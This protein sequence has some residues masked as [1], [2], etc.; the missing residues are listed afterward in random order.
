[1]NYK[2]LKN[3][4]TKKTFI[5]LSLFF[6]PLN[7]FA[8]STI[9]ISVNTNLTPSN[10]P[11]NASAASV[12]MTAD[13]RYVLFDSNAT[14]LVSGSVDTNNATDVFLRDNVTHTTTLISVS[15]AGNTAGNWASLSTSDTDNQSKISPDGRYVLFQSVSSDL[16]TWDTPYSFD[17]FVRDTVAHTTTKVNVNNAWVWSSG[18]GNTAYWYAMTPDGRYVVFYTDATNLV[19]WDTNWQVD[20]FVRDLV[21]NTTTRVSVWDSDNQGNNQSTPSGIS[22]NGR[23]VLFDSYA[24]NLFPWDTNG[25]QDV[26]VRD[27][28]AGTTTKISADSNGNFGNGISSSRADGS[29]AITP[30][31]RYVMFQS[32]ASNLVD[33]DTNNRWDIFVKDM[34]TNITTKVT[35]TIPTCTI[36][37]PCGAIGAENWWPIPVWWWNETPLDWWPTPVWWVWDEDTPI[38]WPAPVWWPAQIWPI[39]EFTPPVTSTPVA[40]TPDGRYVLFSS[41]ATDYVANDTNSQIDGFVRDRVTNTTTRV[42]VSSN[43][44]QHD[45]Y[46]SVTTI[47]PDGRYVLFT[48][49]ASNLVVW[50]TNNRTDVFVRDILNST[51]TRVNVN[52]DWVQTADGR[53]APIDLSSDGRYVLFGSDASNIVSPDTNDRWDV[54]VRDTMNWILYTDPNGV[55][56]FYYPGWLQYKN[57]STAWTIWVVFTRSWSVYNALAPIIT[58]AKWPSNKSLSQVVS[59]VTQVYRKLFRN[60]YTLTTEIERTAYW[61]PTKQLHIT[62]KIAWVDKTFI[63]SFI[64]LLSQVYVISANGTLANASTLD[65]IVDTMISTRKF[66]PIPA[67]IDGNATCLFC[68]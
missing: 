21:A 58:I 40:I 14:D 47:T 62:G 60:N 64:R 49:T 33:W 41:D 2:M 63:I 8:S 17:V 12:T 43:G 36:Q 4:R 23:Y 42:T 65:W 66:S 52:T 10:T 29:S 20:V 54:F 35:E 9:G 7:A 34:L 51:T 39:I 48:S 11:V 15:L 18:G 3:Q 56:S 44:T 37:D 57:P 27:I 26:F 68:E 19:P 55:Y 1:M 6:V 5:V 53:S 67:G 16:V 25:T 50:D 31:A 32:D 46:V 24:S 22:S 61:V 59:W 13:G 28:V 30:N 38:W 45:W